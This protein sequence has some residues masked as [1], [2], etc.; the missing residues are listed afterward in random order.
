MENLVN[1]IRSKLSTYTIHSIFLSGSR[2][3]TTRTTDYDLVVI[4]ENEVEFEKVKFVEANQKYE[5][6]IFGKKAL[7]EKINIAMSLGNVVLFSYPLVSNKG[8]ID[9]EPF[10][11]D[12]NYIQEAFMNSAKRYSKST[13]F[14]KT[15]TYEL[16][17]K[18]NRFWYI[19]LMLKLIEGIT[20]SDE[21]IR[22]FVERCYK[23]ELTENEIAYVRSK[24]SL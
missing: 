17:N 16:Q 23:D 22:S 6:F 19:Y 20:Y 4:V 8:L 1:L 18:Y 11:L 2:L 14:S 5:I 10:P 15:I 12:V 13:F 9:G 24:L 7:Q 3:F 21:Q